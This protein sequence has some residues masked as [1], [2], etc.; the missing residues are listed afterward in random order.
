MPRIVYLLPVVI[1]AIIGVAF[2]LSRS[3]HGR[4]HP[5]LT[6]SRS[7]NEGGTY[8]V[9]VHSLEVAPQT[10]SGKPWDALT[11]RAPDLYYELF[12]RDNRIFASTTQDD[13]LIATWSPLGVD[14]LKS[15]REGRIAIDSVIKAATLRAE[16]DESFALLIYDDDL[17]SRDRI[18][19]LAFRLADLEV[20][21]NR[22]HYASDTAH[23]V[24]QL[25]LHV[26][27]ARQPL[28]EQFEQILNPQGALP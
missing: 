3:K 26:I 16:A 8:F 11:D 2:S 28:L 10:P 14:T 12:W 21:E 27:D 18:A 22:F 7:V 15:I 19:S 17:I 9:F 1:I 5:T 25:V 24:R 23:G 13:R 4:S 20:G 6:S